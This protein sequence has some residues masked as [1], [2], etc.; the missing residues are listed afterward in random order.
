M[1]FI[2]AV[3]S[4]FMIAPFIPIINRIFRERTGWI[5]SLLPLSLFIYFLSFIP[6]ICGKDCITYSVIKNWVPTLGIQLSFYLDG[7]SV[8]FALLVTGIG[9]LIVIY[10]SGYLKGHPFI[11]RFYIY[12]YLFMGSMLGV[13]LSGNLISMFIFWELTSF[14]SY[15]LIGFKNESSESR[16]AALQALFVTGIGGLALLAGI[17]LI[18]SVSGTFEITQLLNNSDLIRSHPLYLPIFLLVLA[19]AFTKSAQLPFHFWLVGAMQ[20]PTPVSAYLHSATMVK[21][22]IY[23]LARLNPILGST[24]EWHYIVTIVGVITMLIGALQALPQTDLKRLLAYT[25]VSALGTLTLLLGI[26]TDLAIKTAMV[27]LIVHS[28]YKGSLFMVAGAIDHTTGTRDVRALG[29]LIRVMPITAVA[30]GLA[31]LSMSGFP[32]LLGFISKELMYEAKLHLPQIGIYITIAGV[33]ANVVNVTV[34]ASVGICPFI[35][36]KNKAPAQKHRLATSLWLGPIVLAAFG[37]FLGLFPELIAIP[38]ISPAVSAIDAEQHIV[39]L[40]L[41]HGFSVVFLLSVLTF[42]LGISIYFFRNFFRRN[43]QRFNFADPLTPTSIYNKGLDGL[44]KFAKLQTN[45]LQSGYMRFYLIIIIAFTTSLVFIE[46]IRQGGISPTLTSMQI[47]FYDIGLAILMICAALFAILTKSRITAAAALGVVGYGVA[48]VYIFF[49]APDLA[50]T[51]FLIETLT[52]ILFVLVVYHLP[53]FTKIS[54]KTSRIR[55]II[56]S[57]AVGIVMT[58][59]VLAALNIQLSDSISYFF[60]ENCYPLT[61]GRNI[62]NVILVDFRGFD[63][64]GEITVLSVAAI[65]VYAMLKL[66]PKPKED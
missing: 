41:W 38:L 51:Q 26:G 1:L 49:G 12:I 65:G 4:A 59:L 2:I 57:A 45:F 48:M 19:G 11:A 8:V 13:V 6:E 5:L 54:E 39:H 40:K 25:T 7:L 28:L 14:S 20:A 52:V 36:K 61:H 63:T 53:G 32:P 43:R 31:A 66:K 47:T 22:G 33:I 27:Y 30:A 37:L 64:M 29:G 55:D 34:A 3:L 15:L 60:R 58:T 50:I 42:I 17:I 9:A 21:A 18:G 10:G 16:H 56:I 23:L 46:L 62:V 35:C 24:T 44:L